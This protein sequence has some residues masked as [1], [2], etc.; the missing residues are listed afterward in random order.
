METCVPVDVEQCRHQ[1]RAGDAVDHAV[2]DLRHERPSI[3]GQPRHQPRFPQRALAL[4]A[5]G[6]MVTGPTRIIAS[7]VTDLGHPN[8]ALAR[9]RSN[10]AGLA[11]LRAR[12]VR[13]VP[14]RS[15]EGTIGR[16]RSWAVA[17][18]E[19]ADLKTIRSA[20]GGSVN[21]VALAVVTAA[22]RHELL[23]RHDMV[24]PDDVM[25]AL[26]PV[27][28]RAPGDTTTNN[29]VSLMVAE[30]PIGCDSP[31]ERLRSITLQMVALKSSHQSDAA[32]LA[33]DATALVPPAIVAATIKAATAAM[34]SMPQHLLNTVVTN[35]PGPQQPLYAMGREMVEY[36][37]FVPVS[38]G[39]RIGVA[40]MS[41]H[42]GMSF[43]L[44]GDLGSVPEL[45][46]MAEQIEIAVAEL[47]DLAAE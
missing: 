22:F 7:W 11:S 29:Q 47:V 46:S 34:H 40:V 12:A 3:C 8:R 26:V 39:I 16:R 24:A 43:G 20:F 15:I 30:L 14:R 42:G 36:L 18:C 41:Y 6:Q 13:P 44:T 27:S 1:S 35:V 17:R 21:D 23:T 9:A 32:G 28:R 31:M 33:F 25:R 38:E 10:L 4:D 19:L 5:V 37:P 2:V 45:R